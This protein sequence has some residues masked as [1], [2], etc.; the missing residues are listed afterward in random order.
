MTDTHII[1]AGQSEALGFE[2]TGPAPYTPTARVQIWVDT[3]GDGVADAWN[4]MRPGGNTGTLANP[5]V[6]GAEVEIAN[7][8]LQ[9]HAGDS[10]NLWIVKVAKGSTGLAAD[11]TQVD[12]SPH[13]TGEMYATATT[14]INGA[15]H[16]L[17]GG[18]YAFS[19]Y[20]VLDWMQGETDAT[21]PVK[22]AAYGAN[23][24]EFIT[25]AR[26]AWHV[27]DV[28]VGRIS[29]VWGDPAPNL[30]V[31][32]AQWGLDNGDSP[33]ADVHTFK[34]M[35]F[36]KLPDGHFDAAG[37]TSLGDAFFDAWAI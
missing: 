32:V 25:D 36:E 13:S 34:T 24:R 28:A 27:E 37:L 35:D 30:A 7:R 8:W 14:A 10:T 4:Y 1:F 16:N 17:D 19:H 21:D 23:V 9:E 5:N 3:N 18:P 26:A 11:P 2:N 12:W 29:G 31:R 15:M 6:W 22:A 33:M 20:D